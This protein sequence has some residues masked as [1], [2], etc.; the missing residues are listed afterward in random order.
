MGSWHGTC[1]VS[2]LPILSGEKVKLTF[3]Y[4]SHVEY[5]KEHNSTSVLNRSGMIYPNDMLSPAFYP[6]NGKYD[7]YGSIKEIEEDFNY[8]IIDKFFKQKFGSKIKMTSNLD[9]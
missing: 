7:D 9:C 6:I 2:R 3:L 1:M 8:H 4:N 5:V